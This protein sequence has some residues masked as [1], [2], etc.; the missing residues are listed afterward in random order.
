MSYK[1]WVR[2]VESG[3]DQGMGELGRGESGEAQGT[4]LRYILTGQRRP[5][6]PTRNIL[7]EQRWPEGPHSA[8]FY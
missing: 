5:K 4:S 6:G 1:D 3:G 7:T 8:S 2:L